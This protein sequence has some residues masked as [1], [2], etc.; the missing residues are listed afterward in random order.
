LVD[1]RK[2]KEYF[3]NGYKVLRK[4]IAISDIDEKT[5]EIIKKVYNIRTNKEDILSNSDKYLIVIRNIADQKEFLTNDQ[6]II[7]IANEQYKYQFEQIGVKIRFNY[8]ILGGIKYHYPP[9]HI[10]VDKFIRCLNPIISGKIYKGEYPGTFNV[11]LSLNSSFNHFMIQKSIKELTDLFNYISTVKRMGF[12]LLYYTV[13]PVRRLV[14][15]TEVSKT[16]CM[17]PTLDENEINKIKRKEFLKE[18]VLIVCKKLNQAYIEAEP[19]DKLVMLWS[20][21][22]KVF[23]GSSLGLLY[24]SEIESILDFAE[25]IE[26][27]KKDSKRLNK[28]KSLINNKAI[29]HKEGRNDVISKNITHLLENE[30]YNEIKKKVKKASSL[31]GKYLHNLEHNEVISIKQ[32]NLFFENV[33]KKYI[34]TRIEGGLKE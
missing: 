23:S 30:R 28:F 26:T 25:N 24:D 14:P 4:P 29:F 22:E 1:I 18:E 12:Q 32:L 10:Q 3:K 19:I 33:L 2:L 7:K 9:N 5:F 11:S 34:E 8:L 6:D 13:T 27:L 21:I 16:E 15:A 17:I 31:R 20:S